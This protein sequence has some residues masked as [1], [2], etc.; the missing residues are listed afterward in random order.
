MHIHTEWLVGGGARHAYRWAGLLHVNQRTAQFADKVVPKGRL[1]V[2]RWNSWRYTC[3]VMI[4]VRG[5]YLCMYECM[6]V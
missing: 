4:F 1:V 2:F 3:R 5:E 6:N